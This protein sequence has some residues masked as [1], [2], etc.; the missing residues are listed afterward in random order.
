MFDIDAEAV[1]LGTQEESAKDGGVIR[2]VLL[3]KGADTMRVYVGR[4]GLAAFESAQQIPE[5]TRV[6]IGLSV[7][8]VG[9]KNKVSLR[10]IAAAAGSKA[11]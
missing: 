5:A 4:D 1:P 8:Q 10:S 9:F 3:S 11:G 7:R 6:R 2:S